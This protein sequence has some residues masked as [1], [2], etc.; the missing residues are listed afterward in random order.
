MENA[1][2]TTNILCGA[3]AVIGLLL[4]AATNAKDLSADE[5]AA[6]VKQGKLLSKEKLDAA[7]QA[8]HPGGSIKQGA[9]VEQHQ[10]G[11]IYEVE[12]TD[13]KGAE[14]DLDI[15]AATGK[16]LKDERD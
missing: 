4:S 8:A 3:A 7:A 11:Y 9:E 16:I 10:R 15:D 1:M 13:A 5:V 14:W 6:L 2:R 12:V